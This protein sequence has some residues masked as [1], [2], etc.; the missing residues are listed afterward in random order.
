M[1]ACLANSHHL[2]VLCLHA[3]IK[4]C[5]SAHLSSHPTL[6]TSYMY[7]VRLHP[8][9]NLAVCTLIECLSDPT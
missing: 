7:I 2:Q 1:S 5:L 6:T 4:W 9:C 3:A 8:V